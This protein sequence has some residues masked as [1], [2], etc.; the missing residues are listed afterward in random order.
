MDLR[1]EISSQYL[2]TLAMMKQVIEKCPDDLWQS[3]DA[4]NH[5]WH[6]AYHPLFYTHLY[7][8]PKEATFTPWEKHRPNL[9]S[10]GPPHWAPDE[11]WERGEP[12]SRAE[13][14]DY[15]TICQKEVIQQTSQLNPEAPSGFDWIPL[16]KLELQFYN[17][18][19][20]QLHI[21]ELCERLWA[22]A[23]IE[24]RWVGQFPNE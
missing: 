10:F 4:T 21:G 7:A 15:L 19:H 20:L 23:Q 5:F 8:Q 1:A 3:A 13:V 16:N 11:A 6:I 14:L 18:R 24:V 12:Y 2:A 9:N 17:I 22:E